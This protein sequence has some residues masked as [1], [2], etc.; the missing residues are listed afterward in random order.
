MTFKQGDT[1]RTGNTYTIPTRMRNQVGTIVKLT[2]A[3]GYDFEVKLDGETGTSLFHSRELT[4]VNKAMT[5]RQAELALDKAN[6]N[7]NRLTAEL[8]EASAARVKA[9]ADLARAR[10]A[11]PAEPPVGADVRFD[12]IFR[13]GERAY[14]YIAL[15]QDNG[16]TITG[17]RNEGKIFSWED[18]LKI[19]DRGVN[20]PELQVR[21]P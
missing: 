21:K 12:V 20:S 17:K 2:D 5:V 18:V 11:I 6:E 1:V 13:H 7:L 15:H 16:W 14:T 8:R 10:A 3:F 4:L 9:H 19:A